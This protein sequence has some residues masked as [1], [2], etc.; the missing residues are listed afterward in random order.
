MRYV[1]R[2]Q[3]YILYANNCC[4]KIITTKFLLSKMSSVSHAFEN[5]YNSIFRHEFAEIFAKRYTHSGGDIQLAQAM[6]YVKLHWR[7][8][9]A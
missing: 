7:N 9:A 8:S 3:K 5:E 2:S 1:I 6:Q 4:R